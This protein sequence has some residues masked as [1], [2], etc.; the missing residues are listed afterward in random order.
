MEIQQLI[1]F[2]EVARLGSFTRAAEAT[3]RSQ[4]AVSQ[5]VQALEN[6]LGCP[7]LERRGRGQ[8]RLTQGG[9]RVLAFAEG[10]LAEQR[11]LR[12]ELDR[13]QGE[14][15]GRLNI[16]A[17]FTTLY[18]LLPQALSKFSQQHPLVELNILDRPQAEVISMVGSGKADLGL[19]PA[20]SV[21]RRLQARRWKKIE[22]YLIVKNRH[23]LS[24][25]KKPSLE[26]IAHWPLIMPPKDLNHAGARTLI[27]LFASHGLEI[28]VAVES[29]NA[30]LTSRFAASGL[31]VGFASVVARSAPPR[32]PGVTFIKLA[33]L[34]DGDYLAIISRRAKCEPAYQEAFVS[35]LLNG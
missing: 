29:S 21:P 18:Q 22:P 25:I 24:K 31:G 1:G 14:M 6:D 9:K 11:D 7:L 17:P 27:D 12:L 28:R 4:S 34:L 3:G 5:Q 19:V 20:S 23:P 33:H 32:Q 13:L 35:I 2:A 30:E 8:L 15:Q 26:E 10:L 16:V